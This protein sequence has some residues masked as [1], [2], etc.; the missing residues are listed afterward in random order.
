MNNWIE[1]SSLEDKEV[2]DKIYNEFDFKPSISNFPSFK[3]PSPFI[4]Y[5][6]SSLLHWSGEL[7]FDEYYDDLENKSLFFFKNS[8][9]RMNICMLSIGSIQVI[10]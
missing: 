5:D 7:T 4:T 8:L 1:L 10:G 6:I 3:V 2:W 9:R